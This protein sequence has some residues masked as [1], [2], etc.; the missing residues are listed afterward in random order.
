MWLR[1]SGGGLT[2]SFLNMLGYLV[3]GLWLLGCK[4][5]DV[6]VVVL[7]VGK[8]VL[9]DVQKDRGAGDVFGVLRGCEV[10]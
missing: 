9:V 4:G 5:P 2:D 10:R 3:I 8:Y 1:G 7:S 6:V